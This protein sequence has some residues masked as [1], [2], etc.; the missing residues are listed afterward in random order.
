MVCNVESIG[1]YTNHTFSSV[2]DVRIFSDNTMTTFVFLDPKQIF[3]Q[4]AILIDVCYKP[5][6]RLPLHSSLIL[7]NDAQTLSH[8]FHVLSCPLVS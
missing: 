6:I 5:I 8:D 2:W 1:E 7:K 3:V 4:W